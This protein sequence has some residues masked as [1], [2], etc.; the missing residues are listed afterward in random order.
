LSANQDSGYGAE[1]GGRLRL[2]AQKFDGSNEAPSLADDQVVVEGGQKEAE[3]AQQTFHDAI[4][5]HLQNLEET[6]GSESQKDKEA[7]YAP[8]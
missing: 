6:V 7:S 4:S 2:L 8:A 5:R 1:I 3:P